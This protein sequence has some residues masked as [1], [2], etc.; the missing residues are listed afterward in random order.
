MDM[1][2]LT[3][4]S[5]EGLNRAQMIADE[6]GNS[7]I[8]PEHI[9]LGLLDSREGLVSQ[10]IARMADGSNQIMYETLVKEVT[11]LIEKKPKVAGTQ[12]VYLSSVSNKVLMKAEKLAQKM[13]DQYVSV[14]HIFMSL[15]QNSE[16]A[17][18]GFIQKAGYY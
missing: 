16:G 2:K 13:N 9:L 7:V 5:A 14:E 10:I 6:Y 3:K 8:D 12:Q 15:L 18:K 1:N 11:S 4:G 17:L